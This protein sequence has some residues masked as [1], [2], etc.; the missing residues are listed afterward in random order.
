M[1]GG[2]NQAW[3]STNRIDR[4]ANGIV[5]VTNLHSIPFGSN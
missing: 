1:H 5:I 3:V 2:E 4:D